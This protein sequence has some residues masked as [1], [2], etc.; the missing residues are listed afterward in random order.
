MAHSYAEHQAI[1]CNSCKR[2][3]SVESWLVVDGLERP[4]LLTKLMS[5]QLDVFVCPHCGNS[6]CVSAPLLICRPSN[7][8]PIIFSPSPSSSSSSEISHDADGLVAILRNACGSEWR[9]EWLSAGL[10]II[11]RS[12]LRAALEDSAT[13]PQASSQIH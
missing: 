8:L 3:C 5:D 13:D 7:R 2:L 10:P 6:L 12:D 9:T 11:E 1:E 4:D